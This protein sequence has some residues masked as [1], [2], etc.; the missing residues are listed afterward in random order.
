MQVDKINLRKN[1]Q[2]D[3]ILSISQR[4][5][6]TVRTTTI[7]IKTMNTRPITQQTSVPITSAPAYFKSQSVATYKD[8]DPKN[9]PPTIRDIAWN[10]TG[11]RI[12]VASS[13]SR[14]R[15]WI[16][17]KVEVNT[18]TEIIYGPKGKAVVGLAWSPVS[19][20]HLASCSLD[21]TVKVWDT[22]TKALLGVVET[23]ADNLACWWSPCGGFIS[24]LRKDN[25]ILWYKPTF[26]SELEPVQ[27]G[28]ASV[29]AQSRGRGN[30]NGQAS[31]KQRRALGAATAFG[32]PI[33]AYKEV[34]YEIFSATW[35]N[36]TSVMAVTLGTG[37][38]K[39]LQLDLDTPCWDDVERVSASASVAHTSNLSQVFQLTGHTTAA[40]CVKPD[41]QGRYIAVGGNEGIVSLWDTQELVCVKTLS[42]H[43]QPV[44]SIDFS[45]DGDYIAV[46]YDSTE[47]PID[48]V[49][50]DTGDFVY[51]VTRPRW[52]GLPV[53][54]WSPVKYNLAFSG[55]VNGLN[56][57]TSDK[58][59]PS[60]Y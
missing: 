29:P 45:H 54:A 39:L 21:G 7:G 38:V 27:S 46:G 14:I 44:V 31:S 52:T 11:T 5:V 41:P 12:A 32:K 35:T 3:C 18:S 36:T 40:N 30:Q 56:V 47:I 16:S 55:D 50:V 1:S 42:K 17:G 34:P 33:A 43:D 25:V 49:H 51:A 9:S 37:V 10:S 24:V 28:P 20:E 15:V 8:K 57:I 22:K 48:I 23:G 59:R 19:S 2:P 58:S 60:G 13:D 6:H 26:V 53:V 4:T